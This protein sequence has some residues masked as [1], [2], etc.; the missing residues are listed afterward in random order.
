MLLEKLILDY[1][2]KIFSYFIIMFNL[3]VLCSD[4]YPIS[5]FY[6]DNLNKLDFIFTFIFLFDYLL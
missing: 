6:K 3:I 2:Y 4:K 5:A 1:R